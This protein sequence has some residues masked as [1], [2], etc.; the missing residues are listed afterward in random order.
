[1]SKMVRK[2]GVFRI[3][4]RVIH[5]IYVN[6]QLQSVLFSKKILTKCLICCID[7]SDL[8]KNLLNRSGSNYLP[9]KVTI[10][11]KGINKRVIEVNDVG[12]DYFEKALFIVKDNNADL[13]NLEYEA[14]RV[15]SSYFP[16][17]SIN[18]RE[19]YLR[20]K[21]RRNIILAVAAS[22]VGFV[23][24]SIVLLLLKTVF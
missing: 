16:Q 2:Q 5:K 4:H 6:H 3:F 14:K 12:S 18:Y 8:D 19:G 20:R 11:I 13:R 21:R 15:V 1:M 17:Y 22:V 23:C 10:M 7:G 9:R 24:L